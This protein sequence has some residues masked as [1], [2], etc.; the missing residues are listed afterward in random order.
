MHQGLRQQGL[1]GAGG[2]EALAQLQAQG[3]Q[4]GYAGDDAGLFGKGWEGDRSRFDL[5]H[6]QIWPRATCRQLSDFVVAFLKYQ[7]D[8]G[9]MEFGTLD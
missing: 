7:L 6:V 1:L 4:G 5:T 2:G 3:A 8:V 9:T